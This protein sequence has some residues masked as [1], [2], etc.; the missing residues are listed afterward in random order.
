MERLRDLYGLPVTLDYADLLQTYTPIWLELDD[1]Q[2]CHWSRWL[3]IA[4]EQLSV[5]VPGQ[6]QDSHSP[7]DLQDAASQ[8]AVEAVLGQLVARGERHA[9]EVGAGHACAE[10]HHASG[11]ERG[12]ERI[13]GV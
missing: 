13:L 3:H 5:S 8:V 11:R 6:Q 7:L 2:T 4:A 1:M 9:P 12:L 10:L